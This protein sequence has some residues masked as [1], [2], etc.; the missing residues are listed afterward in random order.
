M[1]LTTFAAPVVV[2]HGYLPGMYIIG[3]LPFLTLAVGAG[4]ETMWERLEKHTATLTA[5][6]RLRARRAGMACLVVGL[7]PVFWMQWIDQG[8][9]LLTQQ[10]NTDWASTLE[11]DQGN[12][13]EED[14]ILVPYV[15]WQDLNAADGRNDPWSVVATEKADL[16]PQFLVE[17]PGGWR[18]IEWVVVGPSTDE[19]IDGLDL[20]MARQALE[21]SVPMHSVG[22]WSVHRVQRD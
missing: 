3:A 17:H 9:S 11:W 18:E 2:G 5:K 10:A 15:M 13:L 7:L 20:G 14:T 21:H 16:D 19:T 1:A 12:V 6:G 8:R 4:L 22:E